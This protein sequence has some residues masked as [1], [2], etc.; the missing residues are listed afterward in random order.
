VLPVVVEPGAII[1]NMITI[2]FVSNKA[3]R[4]AHDAKGGRDTML[5]AA[6]TASS[7]TGTAPIP[8][9]RI[10]FRATYWKI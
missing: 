8:K 4:F 1:P 3:N 6:A 5:K 7:A 10:G 9:P 2:V